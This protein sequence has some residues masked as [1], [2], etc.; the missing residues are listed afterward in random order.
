VRRHRRAPASERSRRRPAP[1]RGARSTALG[2][3]P[4]VETARRGGEARV[5]GVGRRIPPARPRFRLGLAMVIPVAVAVPGFR[6]PCDTRAR[7]RVRR[8]AIRSGTSVSTRCPLSH[9]LRP[10]ARDAA[11]DRERVIVPLWYRGRNARPC[12]WRERTPPPSAAKV[13]TRFGE[14]HRLTL[15]TRQSVAARPAAAPRRAS[16]ASACRA[17][18]VCDRSVS[19]A[20]AVCGSRDGRRDAG[21]YGRRRALRETPGATGDAGRYGR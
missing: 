3:S 15:D 5:P 4:P 12:E 18:W 13:H 1:N 10:R 11:R 9:S 6:A 16:R 7:R 20:R 14:P 2:R 8:Q 19:V 17:G 21:R